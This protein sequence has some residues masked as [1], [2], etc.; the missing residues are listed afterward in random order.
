[1]EAYEQ[2]APKREVFDQLAGLANSNDNNE[3]LGQLIEAHRK[4]QSSDKPG[5]PNLYYWDAT[6][7]VAQ[8]DHLAVLG[9]L[10]EHGAYITSQWGSPWW[11]NDRRVRSLIRL[12]RFDDALKTAKD[13]FKDDDNPWL[14]ALAYAARGDVE[15]TLQWLTRCLRNDYTVEEFYNDEILGEALRG[16]ALEEVRRQ[17]PEPATDNADGPAVDV[18]SDAQGD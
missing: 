17:H 14:V 2:L 9:I 12:K 3:L 1:M 16:K 15:Q 7:K 11:V 4:N 6:F 8:G 5:D 18:P 10:D 13:S